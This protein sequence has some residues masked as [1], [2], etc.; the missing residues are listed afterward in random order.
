MEIVEKFDF[1]SFNFSWINSISKVG[2]IR[3]EKITPENFDDFNN[4]WQIA[5]KIG[6]FMRNTDG[7]KA[8]DVAFH[9]VQKKQQQR[10]IDIIPRYHGD[11]EENNDTYNIAES[12]VQKSTGEEIK[13]LVEKLKTFLDC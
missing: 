5:T 7:I 11:Y 9:S 1:S 4:M 2:Y 10:Y 12:D 13:L 6:G 8:D 3:M